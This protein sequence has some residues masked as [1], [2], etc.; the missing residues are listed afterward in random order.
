MIFSRTYKKEIRFFWIFIILF[1]AFQ[2][3][4]YIVRPYT[5][6]I[7]VDRLTTGAA[8]K[9]VNFLTPGENTR[10]IDG[11]ISNGRIMVKIRKGCEGIEGML[12]LMAAIFAYPAAFR[13]KAVGILLGIFVIYA[14]NLMRIAGLY[15]IIEYKPSLFDLMHIYVGQIIIIMVSLIFFIAWLSFLEKTSKY[16]HF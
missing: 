3:A 7:L 12:L 13:L 9:M 8:S 6:P 10:V 14:F 15:Y 16:S 4:Y 1:F 2:I 5:T 11:A